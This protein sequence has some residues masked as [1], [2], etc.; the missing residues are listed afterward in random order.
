MNGQS[1]TI[2]FYLLVLL[3]PIIVTDAG[4]CS[5]TTTTTTVTKTSSYT[6]TP[7]SVLNCP[8]C[9]DPHQNCGDGN[10][11]QDGKHCITTVTCTLT[12]NVR[13]IPCCSAPGAPGWGNK[14]HTTTGGGVIVILDSITT[15]TDCC[16]ECM[17]DTQC[18]Q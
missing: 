11:H 10:G 16:K 1:L 12:E 13:E 15:A 2:F 14:I 9:R 4:K 17:A 5:T 8:D 6:T 7:P 3:A 18:L